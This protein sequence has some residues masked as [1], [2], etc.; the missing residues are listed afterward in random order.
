MASEWEQQEVKE[1]SK[2]ILEGRLSILEGTRALRP[3]AYTNAIVSEDDRKLIIGI[4]SETD[5]LPIGEVRKL[6]APSALAEKDP[7]IE[8]YEAVCRERVFAVCRRILSVATAI[9]IMV[10][11]RN[12]RIPEPDLH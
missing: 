4:E 8:R 3:F 6:W 9:Y 11:C 5:H 2:A 12:K 1:I 7:E 10:S